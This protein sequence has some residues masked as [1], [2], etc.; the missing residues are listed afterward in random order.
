[1]RPALPSPGWAALYR[2][3]W[4]KGRELTRSGAWDGWDSSLATNSPDVLLIWKSL[5]VKLNLPGSK[6]TNRNKRKEEK[7]IGFKRNP[8]Q[9]LHEIK[10]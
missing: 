1:M 10:I 7:K 4:R 3:S 5:G 6:A 2:S 8:G 9:T